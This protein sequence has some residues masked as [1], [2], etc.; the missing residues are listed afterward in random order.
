MNF[1][2][3]YHFFSETFFARIA[4]ATHISSIFEAKPKFRFTIYP[5]PSYYIE[6]GGYENIRRVHNF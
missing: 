2:N 5:L 4:H 6:N 3:R 1:K